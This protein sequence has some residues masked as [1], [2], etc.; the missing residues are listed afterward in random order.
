L[1]LL[2]QQTSVNPKESYIIQAI[3][4]DPTLMPFLKE[5]D[6]VE[7]TL[8]AKNNREAYF[9][10]P[11]VGLGIVYGQ[12]FGNAKEIIKR[13]GTGEKV[14]AK[15]TERENA[16][17]Y[18]EL[19]LSEANKQKAWQEIKELKEDDEPIKV[20]IT[21]ANSGGLIADLVGIQAFLPASQLAPEHYPQETEGNKAKIL[22]ELKKLVGQE[23][24]VKI[25]NF[26]PRSNKLIISEREVISEDTKTDLKNYAAGDVVDGIVTGVA[27]FGAFI[28]FANNP[29]IEGLIYISELGHGLIDHP[30][31][32]V[33][34]GDMVKAKVLEIKDG[35]VSLSL[36]AL[37]KD[38]WEGIEG[39]FKEGETVRGTV[40]KLTPFGAFVRLTENISGLIHVSEFGSLEE[41]KNKL[42]LNKEYEFVITSLKPEA[43]RIILKLTT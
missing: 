25:I 38:P 15:V 33:K 41:L 8:V 34:V 5:G 28:R 32:V 42:E 2:M 3:K 17:G 40:H 14:M 37:E 16:Q 6:V 20:M 11:R 13:L 24:I 21:G 18:L 19:S 29:N 31:E 26:T 10:I 39:K 4:A 23:L 7:T 1:P 30:K 27:N 43:R 35:R 9:D 22:E 36:K 12:E